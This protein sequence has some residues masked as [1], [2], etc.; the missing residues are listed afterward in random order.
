MPPPPAPPPAATNQV[1]DA[2]AGE[3]ALALP[4]S[5]W[6][7]IQR[8]LA[9]LGF[10]PGPIDAVPGDRT[11]QAVRQ[12][13]YRQEAAE[14]GYLSRQV[15][16]DLLARAREP[17]VREDRLKAAA[18]AAAE[19]QDNDAP[20]AAASTA[21]AGGNQTTIRIQPGS[22]EDLEA[23][24]GDRVFFNSNNADLSP[25]A[26]ATLDR[27]AA[28][29]TKY[30]QLAVAIA[31]NADDQEAEADGSTPELAVTLGWHRAEA[32][33]NYLAA[34]GIARSRISTISYGNRRPIVRRSDETARA[35]N[36]TVITQVE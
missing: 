28:W 4:Q 34:K 15:L 14:T 33:M 20:D 21:R 10:T 31:G 22:E 27:Q 9:V 5:Q 26:R 36:R 12:F 30:P 16:A 13:Q 1:A 8:S 18:A 6:V 2:Q 3:S 29:L 23:N 17:L 7:L 25:D 19:Q 24:V 35:Q 11:R 32:V